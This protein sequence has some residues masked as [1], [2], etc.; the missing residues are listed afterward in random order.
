MAE[1]RKRSLADIGEGPSHV[2][3]KQPRLE[4]MIE[5]DE[6]NESEPVRPQDTTYKAYFPI[7]KKGKV[8]GWACCSPARLDA[9]QVHHW[10][11]CR[12]G[13]P[14]NE[15]HRQLHA[16]VY[17]D[18]MK[19]ERCE[20]IDHQNHDKRDATDENLVGGTYADNNRNHKRR[21]GLTSQY[22]G[23]VFDR[24]YWRS[25]T[26]YFRTEEAAAWFHDQFEQEHHPRSRNL[27]H[28]DKPDAYDSMCIQG[29]KMRPNETRHITER[30]SG[31]LRWRVILNRKPTNICQSF[32]TKDEA[33]LFRDTTLQRLEEARL[34]EL[35]SRPITRTE[36][37][38]ACINNVKT[39]GF[40]VLMDDKTWRFVQDKGLYVLCDP[41][42]NTPYAFFHHGGRYV[43]LH[44][45]LM[46]RLKRTDNLVVD[47]INLNS[48]DDRMSNL[49]VIDQGLNAQNSA[50]RSH[51]S[52]FKGIQKSGKKWVAK[53]SFN[54]I[55]RYLGTYDTD[56]LAAAAYNAM[57][58]E[59]YAPHIPW[60][61]PVEIP[62]GYEWDT[63]TKR[64]VRK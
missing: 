27:N 51:V 10:N 49:R 2:H 17:Y 34:Q 4:E 6:S 52:N 47:H 21:T 57:V 40:T 19:K 9:V 44:R 39:K 29:T 43:S 54:G 53:T 48:L 24:D 23:V 33:V 20:A 35:D 22:H 32:A 30:D 25:H 60:L 38:V 7:V 41:I 1:S 12:K 45:F 5:D 28:V 63:D 62:G 37:E 59:L 42:S 61:N 50:P 16:F 58:T 14:V 15:K 36:D 31:T 3:D 64:I 46:G 18:L 13:Y 56:T 11:E 8:I 55:H 26:A